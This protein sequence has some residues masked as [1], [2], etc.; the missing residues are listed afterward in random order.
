M[1]RISAAVVALISSLSVA[2]LAQE[3]VVA[4]PDTLK[5]TAGPPFLLAGP[6]LAV[7][8]GD[9]SKEGPYVLRLKLPAGF[10]VAPHS[11]PNDENVTVIS[12]TFYYGTGEKFDESK[13]QAL[14]PGGFVESPKSVKHY[15]WATEE[16]VIQLHGV[17]P[18]GF[19][20]V[21]PEDDPRKK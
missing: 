5:W 12:G 6:Q 3:A 19:T 14:K 7:I 21:N 15:G 16:T 20:Y 9:P 18:S 1:K 13:G 11:H 17:G 8:L 4:Q 10:K 2:A